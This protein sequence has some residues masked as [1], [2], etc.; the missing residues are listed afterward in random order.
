MNLEQLTLSS[1]GCPVSLRV[2]PGSEEAQKM[3]VGSG[4][5]LLE[6]LELSGRG[7]AFSRTLLEY[8]VYRGGFRS[9]TSYLKWKE[10]VTKSGRIVFQ[11]A[12]SA[13]RTKGKG[14]SLW[15][16]PCTYDTGERTRSEEALQPGTLSEQILTKEQESATNMWPT[17]HSTC[18]TG[19]GKQGRQGGE[20]LQTAVQG[21]L[22]PAWVTLLMGFPP[23][24]LDIDGLPD[25][26]KPL[27]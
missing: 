9:T 12:A 18:S 7:G 14:C 5:K 21:Q 15:L 22:N 4:R 1:V 6:L 2:L 8:L 16:T 19:P 3:T 17:P 10:K 25:G 13:H 26:G 24:W 20:N 27:R 23:S 11:L